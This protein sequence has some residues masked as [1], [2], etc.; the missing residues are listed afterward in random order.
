MECWPR[1]VDITDP[2][3]SQYPGWPKTISQFDNYN[4][5]SWG[6]AGE[7]TFNVADPVVEMTDEV[8][9]EVLYTV[10]IKGKT[11]RPHLPKGTT[12]TLKAGRNASDQT[13][14]TKLQV[15]SDKQSIT[16]K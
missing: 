8:S 1:N 16:L 4:P 15:G 6:K 11:F 14:A 7:I 2:K 9:K 12:F 10:R 5:T 13:V 3:T